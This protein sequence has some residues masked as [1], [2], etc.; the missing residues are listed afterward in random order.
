MEGKDSDNREWERKE[1]GMV[2]EGVKDDGG[3]KRRERMREGNGEGR[4][5]MKVYGGGK[6][7]ELWNE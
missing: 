7:R 2:R 4:K 5:G 6:R 3:G 1:K